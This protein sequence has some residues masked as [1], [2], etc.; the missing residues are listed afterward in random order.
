[1]IENLQNSDVI[2]DRILAEELKEGIST[3]ITPTI[4][5]LI[6]AV[7]FVAAQWQLIEQ[8]ILISWL[9][10]ITASSCLTALISISYNR[11]KPS[12]DDNQKWLWIFLV[13]TTIY[14]VV[15][16]VGCILLFPPDNPVH[17]LF[18]AIACISV[19][20]GATVSISGIR[21]ASYLY[22]PILMLPVLP[23]FIM[24]GTS[25]AIIAM[26]MI[27]FMFFYFIVTS[28]TIYSNAFRNIDLRYKAA[29][30]REEA[31][32][33]NQSKSEFLAN[34]SHEIRTPMNA[35]IGMSKLAL[36]TNLS[37][38]QQD[39]IEKV[40]HSAESLLGI[41]NDILDFSKIEAD[42]LEIE[43]TDFWL[44]TIFDEL[45][46]II[47][48]K[49]TEKGLD[50]EI[51]VSPDVPKVI[52]GDPLR[53]RQILI[54]LGNNAIKF[55]KQGQITISVE[56]VEQHDEQPILQFCVCDTG[57]GM[58]LEQQNRLFQSFSQADNTTYRKYGG[59]GLGL[60]ISKKLTELMGGKIWVESEPNRGSSFYFTVQLEIGNIS[61]LQYFEHVDSSEAITHLHEARV[62]L[63]EDNRLNQE[64]ATALLRKKGILVTQAWNGKEALE[65][66]QTERFDGVLMDIQMPVMDGYS[67]TQE[68]RKLPQF[69]D[70]PIIAM[71]ASVMKGDREKAEAAGMNDHI[72]K[73]LDVDEM[74]ITMARWISP[75]TDRVGR[76]KNAESKSRPEPTAPL[77]QLKTETDKEKWQESGSFEGLIGIDTKLG[78]LMNMNDYELYHNLLRWFYDDQNDFEEAFQAARESDDLQAP[79]RTAHTLK[80]C[81][82][83]IGATRIQQAALKLESICD[84]NGSN[85]EISSALQR[86]ITELTPVIKSLEHIISTSLPTQS[87]EDTDS[88]QPIALAAEHH[89]QNVRAIESINSECILIIDDEPTNL[90][91]LEKILHSQNYTNLMLV[92]DSREVLECYQEHNT[93][94]ILLDINMPHLDGYQVMAQLKALNDPLLPPII[95]LTAQNNDEHLLRALAAGARDYVTKPF[96]ANELLMR[97]RN[98][99]DVQQ[100]HRLVHNQKTVL[101]EMVTERTKELRHSQLDVVKRLG[102]AAEYRDEETG[103]HILRM[104]H[105]S[106]LLAQGLGWNKSDCELILNASMMHDIGKI[107]IPDN[108]LLKTEKFEP[109]EWEIMKSHVTIGAKL[110]SDGDSEL[111]HMAHDIVLTHHEWWDGSGY[112]NGLVGEAI[113]QAGRIAALADVIDALTSKRPYKEAWT[114]ERAVAQI[115]EKSGTHFDPKL[116]EVFL[117]KLPNILKVRER[118]PEPQI[119]Y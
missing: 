76:G 2:D 47:E 82:G 1:M 83:S 44:P 116:V 75:T 43:A 112:P 41:I 8:Y 117:Q 20:A 66:L 3:V 64:L 96:N 51:E 50:L 7:L 6:G 91:L 18:V 55:T 101:E 5:S 36:D 37:P 107:G 111:M 103:T 110:L 22:L 67:A 63:V 68:I 74:F 72:A 118:F 102:S 99:L 39:Y 19:A 24:E 78:L 94:L 90:K 23:L 45:A 13:S 69:K 4:L 54:N 21:F 16:G 57:V 28:R 95:I 35:V 56:M 9:I 61:Q 97:V 58:N 85:A 62:L 115:K 98:L 27:L 12:V 71:T 109:H 79:T 81:A 70:L 80:G 10:A 92:Q 32:D 77:E 33:A 86:V 108:I 106:L 15:W 30:Y 84:E 93:S 34:M 88:P 52:K 31:E 48:F 29:K 104:S 25:D 114:V 87:A 42:K 14:G 26:L 113:P 38:R 17:Q 49:A 60:S 53:L 40:H 89:E 119:N 65:I 100:A 59:T 46:S 73:P 105:I 11:I